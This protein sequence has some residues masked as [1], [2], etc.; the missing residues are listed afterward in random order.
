MIDSTAGELTPFSGKDQDMGKPP[1]N[2]K[3]LL[4]EHGKNGI[5][6]NGTLAWIMSNRDSGAAGIWRQ[7]AKHHQI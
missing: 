7:V 1:D 6:V 5:I 3:I 4:E 2:V